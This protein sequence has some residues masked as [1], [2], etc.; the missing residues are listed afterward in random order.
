MKVKELLDRVVE[1]LAPVVSIVIFGSV[2]YGAIY[3]L[4]GGKGV[5]TYLSLRFFPLSVLTEFLGCGTDDAKDW[6]GRW[7]VESD[8]FGTAEKHFE[9][10]LAEQWGQQVEVDLSTIYEVNS[11]G[12][13]E[14]KV[15]Q[16]IRGRGLYL[17]GGATI[18]GSYTLDGDRFLMEMGGKE[19]IEVWGYMREE[20]TDLA[21]IT[22][23]GG[24]WVRDG[25]TLTLTDDNLVVVWKKE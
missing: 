25:D 2:F 18:Q 19:N 10:A 15:S 9:Q 16:V 7:S 11:D 17:S 3:F 13:F 14:S 8:F 21:K 12:T 6:V 1:S 23:L 20:D 4:F 22:T 5:E 24:T